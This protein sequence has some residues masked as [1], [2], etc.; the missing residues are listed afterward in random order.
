MTTSVAVR[1]D[2]YPTALTTDD[3]D[4][5]QTRTIDEFESKVLRVESRRRPGALASRSNELA[6]PALDLAQLWEPT[7]AALDAEAMQS[8][9]A[10]V[11]QLNYKARSLSRADV[12][13][14]WIGT[15]QRIVPGGFIAVLENQ[16]E[17]LGPS[18]L[19]EFDNDSVTEGDQ[20]LLATGAVFYFS[21]GY[22]TDAKGTRTSFSEV[23]FRRLPVWTPAEI[24]SLRVTDDVDALF[25]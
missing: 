1:L 20:A 22:R 6:E 3:V 17:P 19:A 16:D 25:E 11:T 23:R 10:T 14:R 18:E 13:G 2:E 4:R 15:V 7:G 9:Y 8:A 5:G 21:V 24:R 12:R